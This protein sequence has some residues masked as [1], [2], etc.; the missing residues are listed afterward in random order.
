M[1]SSKELE[2]PGT[3]PSLKLRRFG[4]LLLTRDQGEPVREELLELI[5]IHGQVEVDLDDVEAYTPSF[6][7]EVLGKS[8]E[9]IGIDRFRKD[10][11]LVASSIGVRKLVNLV[12]S[13]RAVSRAT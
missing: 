11:K 3:A 12:L 9:A 5:M 13:N 1:G 6:M 8:L 7:D 4:N 2:S 10:V